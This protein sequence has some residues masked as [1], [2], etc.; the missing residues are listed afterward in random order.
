MRTLSRTLKQKFSSFFLKIKER[1]GIDT[2]SLA[3]FRIG[4]ALVILA[5]LV[6]RAKNLAVFYT[7]AGVLPRELIKESESI[8][9]FLSIHLLDGSLYFE[10]AL[11][12]IAGIVALALLVGYRTKWATI[13]SWFLLA[14]LQ[15][16]N[17]LIH[18]GGDTLLYFLIFWGMFLP[19][20]A[21]YSLDSLRSVSKKKAPARVFSGGSVALFLQITMVYWFAIIQKTGSEWV[22]EGTAVYY[23]LTNIAFATPLGNVLLFSFQPLLKILNYFAV[24]IQIVGPAMLLFPFFIGPLRTAAVLLFIIFHTGLALTMKLDLFPL[25]N[26]VAVIP[27]LPSWFWDKTRKHSKTHLR[28]T[29]YHSSPITNILATMFLFFIVLINVATVN[30][31]LHSVDTF[32]FTKVFRLKQN[33]GVFSPHPSRVNFSYSIIGLLE[34]GEKTE[35]FNVERPLGSNK[36]WKKYMLQMLSRDQRY[37]EHRLRLG[38]YICETSNSIVSL[39]IYDIKEEILLNYKFGEKK[40]TLLFNYKCV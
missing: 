31:N 13:I 8:W 2:R 3:L 19:L 36:H 32:W 24:V 35:L 34:N 20:G 28:S 18:N 12:V 21:R 14:S 26:I 7:D 22:S 17:P 5:D 27:F 29:E 6:S 15:A 39:D 38:K 4:V 9:R 1:Y 30:P 11:F 23:A 25:T 37:D 33:W 40:R 16:R 10:A